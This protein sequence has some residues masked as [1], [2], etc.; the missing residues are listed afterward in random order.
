MCK[1]MV[2]SD[3]DIFKKQEILKKHGYE[4]LEQYEI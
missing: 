4:I 1:E 2:A 3:I